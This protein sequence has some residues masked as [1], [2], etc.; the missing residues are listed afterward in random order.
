MYLV[1]FII[2]IYHDA[3]SPE[4]QN[5]ILEL[6]YRDTKNVEHEMCDHT[7]NNLS[8]R[9]G[10]RSLKNNLEE[11]S[12]NHSIDQYKRKPYAPAIL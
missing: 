9:N 5:K 7:G 8:H 2:G 1:G 4:R 6:T 11:E 10:N 3:R 12:G